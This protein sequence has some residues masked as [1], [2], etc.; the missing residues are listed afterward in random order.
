V[1]CLDEFTCSVYA[2]GELPAADASRVKEH[3]QTCSKCCEIVDALRVE[4][5]VLIACLQDLDGLERRLK[6]AAAA[7]PGLAE[8]SAGSLVTLGA[9]LIAA[10]MV[11]R[12]AFGFLGSLALPAALEWLDPTRTAGQTNLLLNTITYLVLEGGSM[13]DSILNSATLIALNLLAL[14]VITVLLR[15]SIATRAMLS[16]IAL[17][18]VFS[19]T[20]YAL[21][22]RR[23][24]ESVTVP[25]GET[26]DDTLVVFGDS[27]NV[28]GTV[29]GD[30]IAFARN[31]SVRGMVKGNVIGF[32]QHVIVEG[33]VEGSILGFGQTVE[34][35]GHVTN[36]IYGFGQN[37][38]IATGAEVTGNAALFGAETNND[39]SIGRDLWA[40]CS[41]ADVRGNVLRNVSAYAER[42]NVSA[43]ARIV[44]NLTAHVRNRN[45]VR[46]ESGA[47]VGGKTDI[48]VSPPEPNRYA[49]FSFYVRQILWLA[50]AFL[51]GMVLFWLVPALTNVNLDSA[52][53]LLTAAG[54]G[55]LAACATPIAAII[56]AITLIG[57]PIGLVTLA[58]W[59][60]CLYLAKIVL[61]GFMGRALLR[62][63]GEENASPAL[64]LL[65]G[66]V[67]V[68]IAINLPYVGGIISFFLTLL[69]LGA[70]IMTL[71][72]RRQTLQ[73]A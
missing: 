18:A 42:V 54:I 61:A 62:G 22:I 28:D 35:R 50:A 36:N 43:P 31:V 52:R 4:S 49:T 27:V 60:L 68:L 57:L 2:D 40:F 69:G 51:T 39:G 53:A 24:H 3:L 5:R 70:M 56:V 66:L 6:P 41:R 1:A 58:L 64:M 38:S 63:Q 72:N 44:G 55:F 14:I 17:L 25:Q 59:L 37:V 46:I 30:L 73:A 8:G 20:S 7:A 48:Q 65:V 10:A 13:M 21:D 15:R 67:L 19:S 12:A 33:T 29:N 34:T 45:N 71:Y 16:V 47:T 23:G 26:I 32:G 9:F 11:I